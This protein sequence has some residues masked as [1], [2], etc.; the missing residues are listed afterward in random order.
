MS[1]LRVFQNA[2]KNRAV[3]GFSLGNLGTVLLMLFFLPYMITFAMGNTWDDKQEVS[4][5]NE[6]QLAESTFVIV[7]QTALGEENIPLEIYVADKL[8]RAMGENYEEEA[9]KAQAVLIRTNLLS[10]KKQTIEIEDAAYGSKN[11]SE[12]CRMA[13]YETRGVYL[14]YEKEPVYAAY[15]KVSSGV[16]RSGLYPYL[17]S[18]PCNRDFLSEEYLSTVSFGK[19]SF[20]KKWLTVKKTDSQIVEAEKAEKE[21]NGDFSL[22][23]D[24]SGYVKFFAY[25]DEWV[26]GEEFRYEYGLA[27]SD[28]QISEDE[29]NIIFEV[30]GIGHGFGMSQF[31]ANEVAKDGKTYPEILEYFFQDVTMTKAK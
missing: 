25:Q 30:K 9:L 8:E 12:K 22:V 16:T 6:E 5:I 3:S 11:V 10:Q 17:K 21:K 7:N 1:K 20:E 2:K 23:R 31:G 29:R 13:V 4:L 24:D 15:F 28:F 26:Q 14:Q 27:S 19:E 18:V